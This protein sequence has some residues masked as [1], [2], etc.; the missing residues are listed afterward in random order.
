MP[1]SDLYRADRRLSSLWHAPYDSQAPP[2]SPDG[3]S[4]SIGGTSP[5]GLTINGVGLGMTKEQVLSLRGMTSGFGPWFHFGMLAGFIGYGDGTQV[6]FDQRGRV[7]GVW[8]VNLELDGRPIATETW[9]RQEVGDKYHLRE[10]L[11]EPDQS[12]DERWVY[13][14]YQLTVE[15]EGPPWSF[16]L[17]EP[18]DQSR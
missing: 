6:K 9:R 3:R 2:R 5:G 1:S 12:S 18:Y 13:D 10:A 16:N 8:G 15:K 17:G 11:G 4:G 14:H 7:C